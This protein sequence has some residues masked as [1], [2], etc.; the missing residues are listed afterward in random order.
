MGAF[1]F[2]EMAKATAAAMH[3]LKRDNVLDMDIIDLIN[4]E[5]QRT[6]LQNHPR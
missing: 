4:K 2:L 1:F 6:A 5:T 3:S